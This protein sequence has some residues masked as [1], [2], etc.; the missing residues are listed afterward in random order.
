M[1]SGI[2]R[3]FHIP[4][5]VLWGKYLILYHLQRLKLLHRRKGRRK[6]HR[7]PQPARP[8]HLLPR[9]A[10]NPRP[11]PTCRASPPKRRQAR[12]PQIPNAQLARRG[13]PET[14][15]RLRRQPLQHAPRP[16]PDH[17]GR[18]SRHRRL[19]RRR[20]ARSPRLHAVA[21]LARRQADGAVLL[22]GPEGRHDPA[23]SL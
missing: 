16:G 13:Q 12:M 9:P 20:R 22:R 10:P 18:K 11:P 5:L 19:R 14:Q 8:G 7:P 23:A 15:P 3:K 4:T 6:L 1:P 17:R 21:Q 2:G